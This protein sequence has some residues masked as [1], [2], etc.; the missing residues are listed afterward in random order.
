MRD[1]DP[2]ARTMASDVKRCVLNNLVYC[3][4]HCRDI[5][6]LGSTALELCYVAAGRLDAY[7]SLG[8]KEWDFAAA[9]LMVKEA[10]GC[11]I[12]FDGQP[13]E[14]H[15]RRALAGSTDALAR[16]FVGHLMAPGLAPP[17]GE[18]LLQAL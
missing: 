2:V 16:S 17:G 13:L 6:H 3:M 7:Q 9:V 1:C 18:E 14:L 15:K 5:R 12:D 11:V 8:P 10:G 4:H